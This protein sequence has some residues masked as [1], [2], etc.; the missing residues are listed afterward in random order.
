MSKTYVDAY[1]NQSFIEDGDEC[2]ILKLKYYNPP[3]LIFQ[4]LPVEEK[5]EIIEV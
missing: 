1:N 5:V 2:A 4:H 3:D